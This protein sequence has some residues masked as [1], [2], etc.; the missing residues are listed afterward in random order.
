MSFEEFMSYSA[1]DWEQV[2][3]CELE[4]DL[5]SILFKKHSSDG[6]LKD[7]YLRDKEGKDKETVQYNNLGEGEW[8]PEGLTEDNGN[9][10]IKVKIWK[11]LSSWVNTASLFIEL[12]ERLLTHSD[13]KILWVSLLWPQK[14]P[15]L[16]EEG[17]FPQL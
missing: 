8:K 6:I 2:E 11:V 10:K 16:P 3:V 15:I 12:C 14:N 13:L 7:Q 4:L 1:G 9:G 5:I 17:I